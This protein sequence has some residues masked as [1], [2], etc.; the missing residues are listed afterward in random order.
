MECLSRFCVVR[1]PLRTPVRKNRWVG[2]KLNDE[3]DPLLQSAINAASLRLR[4]THRPGNHSLRA[5]RCFFFFAA[6]CRAVS[7][8]IINNES[9]VLGLIIVIIL[10][11][12]MIQN[13][14]SESIVREFR[15]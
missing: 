6:F 1:P 8:R 9:Y 5:I 13:G 7:E 11:I 15:G 3:A 12:Q 4:E 14:L 2:A 10:R